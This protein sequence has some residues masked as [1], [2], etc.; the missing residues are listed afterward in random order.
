MIR[1]FIIHGWGGYPEEGWFPWLKKELENMGVSVRVPAMPNSDYPK[2]NE[3]VP[4]LNRIVNN[5]DEKT[6]FVGHSIGCQ[7]ILRY[8]ESLPQTVKVGGCVLVAPWVKL[9]NLSEEEKEIAM[10]WLSTPIKWKKILQ[11]TRKFVCIFS[12]N[13]PYVPLTDA[14]IFKKKLK[15]KIVLEKNKYHFS[16]EDNI[17]KLPVVLDEVSKMIK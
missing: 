17:K 16:G 10:P 9:M 1:V 15:A 2:I 14:E 5:P 8:L 3:W 7:T 13:D 4:F 12:D 6:F 11:H